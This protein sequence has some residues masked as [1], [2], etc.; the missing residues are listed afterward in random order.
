MLIDFREFASHLQ[1]NIGVVSEDFSSDLM[2]Y[3]VANDWFDITPVWDGERMMIKPQDFDPH[4]GRIEDYI[5]HKNDDERTKSNTLLNRLESSFPDT[6]IKLSRFYN[7]ADIMCSFQYRV[8]SFLLRYLHKDVIF[9]NDNELEELVS[10]AADELPLAYGK[11]LVFFFAWV[12]DHYK[13]VY[14]RSYLMEERIDKSEE[15][16]SYAKEEYLQ[17]M[18]YLFNPD[19]IYDNEMYE[20][21][22]DDKNYIDTWLHMSL[23]FLN[24]IRNSD[25]LRLYH[26]QLTM[27]PEEVLSAVKDGIFPDADARI[28]LSSIMYHMRCFPLKPSKTERFNN[29]PSIK[30]SV[31][32][33]CEVH[34]GTLFAIAEAHHQ[35]AGLS[36]EEPL[37]HIISD[38]ESINRYMGEEIGSLF[39]CSNFRSRGMNKSYLQSIMMM[40]DEYMDGTAEFHT[41]G[42]ILA[43]LARSHKGGFAEFAAT[44]S[45][46]VSNGLTAE[47]VAR[48]L[49]ERKALSWT[50]KM[51]LDILT[52]GETATLPMNKQ[53]ELIKLM[54][55]TPMEC[56]LIVRHTKKQR[57]KVQELLTQ[58]FSTDD[59]RRQEAIILVL[60]RLGSGV[61]V[62]K[63][64]E[65]LP[66]FNS[67]KIRYPEIMTEWDYQ[68]N[69]LLADPDKVLPGSS[70]RVFFKCNVCKR[71][72]PMIISQRV[73]IYERN[74]K[75]IDLYSKGRI[76]RFREF[77]A[78]PYCKGYRRKLAYFF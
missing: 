13:T 64:D 67:F 20:K 32:E 16:S 45:R 4:I 65:C 49:W 36:G 58:I 14:K 6:A 71:T 30:F 8:T 22:A 68:N 27:A 5:L 72:Y 57:A 18:Y 55:L 9:V 19:Y 62:S 25:L 59:K 48:E 3:L 29:I 39:A 31:P 60:H 74:Q 1:K 78:C 42:Y 37:I 44:T 11:C 23:H 69:Y 24:A 63:Q 26:P 47:S 54:N 2:E 52:R 46:Y 15:C 38:Y 17:I 21:A 73:N 28:T 61:A 77:K 51:L 10:T 12:K 35:L 70:K 53:T 7:A 50:T 56:E 66:G 43:A 75:I 34:I 76:S 33:S 41:K 40:T